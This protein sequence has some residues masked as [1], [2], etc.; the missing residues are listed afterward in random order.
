MNRR[1]MEVVA[2]LLVA[3]AA[4]CAD[5]A[6][7]SLFHPGPADYQQ[8]RAERYDPYPEKDVGPPVVGARPRE[9][10]NP[11]AEVLR[12]RWLPWNWGRGSPQ[13]ATVGR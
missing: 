4:G 8:R 1:C 6:R 10:E 12:A 5:V 2:V 11:P 3:G 13:D 9:Y 7:P